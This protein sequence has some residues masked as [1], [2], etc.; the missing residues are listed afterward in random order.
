MSKTETTR[1]NAPSP[2]AAPTAPAPQFD[3]KAVASAA[4]TLCKADTSFESAIK[5]VATDVARILTDKPTFD[6]WEAIAAAFQAD[7]A[8]ARKCNVETARKRWVAVCAAMESEFALEK[9]AKPTQAAAKK[10]EERKG[11]DEQA[12]ALIKAAGATTPQAMMALTADASKPLP[13][14]VVASISKLAA[15]AANEASK[16]ANEA[17]RKRAAELRESI[18]KDCSA[19]DATALAKVAEFIATLKAP[20]AAPTSAPTPAPTPEPAQS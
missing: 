17:A 18:R 7:Y 4:Q 13:R 3:R 12:A 11:N 15:E 14:G 6:A 2:A 19:L 5:A 20:A 1:A 8:E 9:P 10:A 16:A